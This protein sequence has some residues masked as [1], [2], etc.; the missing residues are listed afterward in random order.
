[1]LNGVSEGLTERMERTCKTGQGPAL[2]NDLCEE[3]AHLWA[4]SVPQVA[5]IYKEAH[6][7][8]RLHSPRIRGR[9]QCT[10]FTTNQNGTEV[11]P[12][13]TAEDFIFQA[14]AQNLILLSYVAAISKCSPHHS[15]Q[16]VSFASLPPE[17]KATE[18]H[19]VCISALLFTW[20][21]VG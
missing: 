20:P 3:K 11:A 19:G 1:M 21:Y 17:L 7:D 13:E 6:L 8:F 16:L 14:G 15:G 2:Q 12:W 9:W 4:T 10:P 18:Q 5:S